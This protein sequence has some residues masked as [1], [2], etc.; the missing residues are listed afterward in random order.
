LL[1]HNI[2][3]ALHWEVISMDKRSESISAVQPEKS[4]SNKRSIVAHNYTSIYRST[5]VVLVYM[6]FI[7][8][9]KHTKASGTYKI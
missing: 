5:S 9:D 1:A 4:S 8:R 2:V 3:L 7:D 6:F